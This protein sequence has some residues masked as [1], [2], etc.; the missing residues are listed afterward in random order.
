MNNT[1]HEIKPWKDT[2][3]FGVISVVLVL[4]A[5]GGQ[6]VMHETAHAEIFNAY[7]CE[8]VSVSYGPE[9]TEEGVI[10]GETSASC[11]VSERDEIK[12]QNQVVHTVNKLVTVPLIFLC[13]SVAL[14]FAE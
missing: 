13:I 14:R 6:T 10:L 8:N 2:L 5:I 3:E 4:L 7:G 1:T 12:A 11:N 9:L